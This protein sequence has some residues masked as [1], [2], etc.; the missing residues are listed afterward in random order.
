MTHDIYVF[1]SM[2]RFIFELQI[3]SKKK[4]NSLINSIKSTIWF[5]VHFS[6][7]KKN[8]KTIIMCIK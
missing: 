7:E 6:S 8:Y 3:I 2:I 4:L 1:F 5:E